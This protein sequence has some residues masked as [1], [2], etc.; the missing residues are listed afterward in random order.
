MKP[1]VVRYRFWPLAFLL[2]TTLVLGAGA[3][4][5][6][7]ARDLSFLVPQNH[8]YTRVNQE[9]E[10]DFGGGNLVSVGLR[11]RKRQHF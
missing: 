11:F 2:V 3:L 4:R 8:P 6:R 1:A 10:E 9:M 7:I 5:F